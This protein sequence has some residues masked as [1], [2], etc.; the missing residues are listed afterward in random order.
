MNKTA[1]DILVVG[2]GVAGTLAAAAASRQGAS[3]VLIEKESSLG[4]IGYAGMFQNI[5]GLYL[6]GEQA[7]DRTLNGGLVREIVDRLES[8]SPKKKMRRMGKVFVLPCASEGLK[9][10]LTVLTE[11]EPNLNVLLGWEAASVEARQERIESVTLRRSGETQV[12]EPAMVVDCS[13]DGAAAALAGAAYDLAPS[14]QRQLAG[15]T[16]H[17]RGLKTLDETLAIKVPYYLFQAVNE[18]LLAQPLKYTTFSPG[19]APDEGYI[20][21]SVADDGSG[22][23]DEK[24]RRDAEF[25]HRHLASVVPAFK[26]SYIVK[27]SPRVLDRETRRVRGEY[28]LTEEDVLGARKFSDGVVRNSWPIELWDREKGTTYQYLPPGE[29]YEIPFR[30]LLVKNFANLLT[31][32]RCISAT[33]AALGSARVMG[34]CMAMGEQA[35]KAAAYRVRNGRYPADIKQFSGNDR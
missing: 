15:F 8:A 20:K 29:Y 30:C 28:T 24:A 13:G 31:A 3:T 14:G 18:G 35:G 26:D 5:C 21:M 6:N 1:C 25:L 32:G 9:S 33:P 27:T 4:G 7:P 22:E 16:V 2:G 17:V 12:I 34:A 11:H 10:V 23:R 19:D